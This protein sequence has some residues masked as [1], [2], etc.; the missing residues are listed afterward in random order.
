[1]DLAYFLNQRLMFIEYFHANTTANF[2]DVKRKIE[3]GEPPYVDSRYGEDAD[4]P[5]FLEE[6]EG[7]DAAVTVSGAA[8]LDLLQSTFHAFLSAYMKQIGESEV[9]PQLKR[10]N[11]KGW[12][13]NYRTFFADYLQIDWGDSAAD[14]RVYKDLC[15]RSLHLT[16]RTKWRSIKQYWTS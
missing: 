8:C 10:L 2:E 13:G 3:S 1:M 12:F 15:K 7:A 6:W 5:A 16:R 4:E 11:K 14:L 9:I